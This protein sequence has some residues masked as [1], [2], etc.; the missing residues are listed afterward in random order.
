MNHDKRDTQAVAELIRAQESVYWA[1]RAC[2]HYH[3]VTFNQTR[4]GRWSVVGWIIWGTFWFIYHAFVLND[5]FPWGLFTPVLSALMVWFHLYMDKKRYLPTLADAEKS[6]EL[7][8]K[9]YDEIEE[10]LK[11]YGVVD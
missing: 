6:M 5:L 9:L 4:K 1:Y 8:R 3:H 11:E 2:E 7:N 10:A